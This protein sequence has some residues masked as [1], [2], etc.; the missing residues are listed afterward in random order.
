M[1]F[2]VKELIDPFLKV[3]LTHKN[4]NKSIELTPLMKPKYISP[5]SGGT[6]IDIKKFYV[7]KITVHQ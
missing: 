2:T 6:N 5:P 1:L 7:N 4:L 3:W